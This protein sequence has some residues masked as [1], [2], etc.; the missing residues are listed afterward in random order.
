MGIVRDHGGLFADGIRG[1]P[2]S[3]VIFPVIVF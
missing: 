1:L 3:D 2:I